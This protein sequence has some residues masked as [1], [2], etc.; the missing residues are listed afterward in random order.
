LVLPTGS[1]PDEPWYDPHEDEAEIPLIGEAFLEYEKEH[2]HRTKMT[3]YQVERAVSSFLTASQLHDNE[4]VWAITR[5]ACKTWRAS[6]MALKEAPN[7]GR[8]PN[9]STIQA[10]L[11]MV[12][13]FLTWCAEREWLPADLMKGLS[14][15]K[16]LVADSKTRKTSF[17]EEELTKIIP[18]LLAFPAEDLPRTEFKWASLALMFSG[19]RCLEIV[20]L[21][22]QDIRQVDGIWVFDFKFVDADHR[23]KNDPSVRLVP[24]HSQVIQY[25]FLE[26]VHHQ[27]RDG[28]RVFPLLHPKGSNLVSMWFTRMLKALNLKRPAVS[29]HSLRHTLTVKLAQARTFPPLQNRLLG[30]AIGKSVED[31]VYLAGLV[32]S[33]KDLSEALETVKFP[34]P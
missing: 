26:W 12:N 14:L 8:R 33:V 22:H 24:I 9:A 32:F 25:G 30:H 11:R 27:P 15:P 19:A 20:Q 7:G 10:R 6:L 29:L 16:R 13:H 28:E 18:T 34:I 21:R 5:E 1:V 17:T 3:R 4:P 23:V 2:S 31:R